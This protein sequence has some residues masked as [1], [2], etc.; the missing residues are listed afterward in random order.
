M[1]A[2]LKVYFKLQDTV[3]EQ[4]VSDRQYEVEVNLALE[5]S[6]TIKQKFRTIAKVNQASTLKLYDNSGFLV[7]FA[8]LVANSPKESYL[9]RCMDVIKP[10]V[11]KAH[12]ATMKVLDEINSLSLHVT[13]LKDSKI[14]AMVRASSFNR[15]DRSQGCCPDRLCRTS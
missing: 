15:I 3:V 8:G 5:S 1:A 14:A 10:V 12:R 7:N 13:A 6:T 4:T 2:I 9:L 11:S